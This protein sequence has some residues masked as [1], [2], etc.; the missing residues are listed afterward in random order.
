MT[1]SVQ[2]IANTLL[3]YSFEQ[4]VTITPMKLQKLMYFIYR[5]YLKKTDKKL[6]QE[7]FL[8]WQYGPVLSSVY[9]EFKSFGS[10]RI[11]KF[12]K[13]AQEHVY[14]VS[15]AKAPDVVETINTVWE[16]YKA[17]TGVELSKLTHME[18]TAWRKAAENNRHCL[19]DEDIKNES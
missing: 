15:E 9:D 4:K 7:P 6:F 16:N 10:E 2:A 14:I 8:T 3:K 5:D 18:G 19:E 11:T 1:S 13:D 17:Y 12:A